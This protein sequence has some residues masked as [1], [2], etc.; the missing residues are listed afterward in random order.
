MTSGMRAVMLILLYETCLI[1]IMYLCRNAVERAYR[2][3]RI[4]AQL[5]LP[6]ASPMSTRG[7]RA[8]RVSVKQLLVW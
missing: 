3:Y 4:L 5:Q 2:P 8:P 1:D 7:C 6:P